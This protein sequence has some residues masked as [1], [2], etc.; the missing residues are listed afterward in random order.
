MQVER[1]IAAI[2]VPFAVGLTASIFFCPVTGHHLHLIPVTSTLISLTAALLLLWSRTQTW[3]P[4]ILTATIAVIFVS[5]GI[6]TGSSGHMLSISGTEDTGWWHEKASAFGNAMSSAIDHIPF[7]NPASNGIIKALITGERCGIPT[8]VAE[9]FRESGAAHILALSGLHLG[10]IYG[11]LKFVLSFAGNTPAARIMKSLTVILCCGFYTS[12]TGCGPS[13]TRAFLFILIGES[14]AMTGRKAGLAGILMTS[15]LI[16]TVMNPTSVREAGFQMSYAAVAGIAFIYPHLKK[17][18]PDGERKE[19]ML[20]ASMRWIWN[21]ASMSISCQLTTGPLA[22]VYF[23][24]LP[25]YF[26]LT[27]LIAL[28]LTGILIP[29]ALV[30]LAA[31]EA[32]VCPMILI[33]VTEALV[34]GLTEALRIIAAP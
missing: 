32:G 20:P 15:F 14:A 9:A 3:N 1:D 22:Y 7:D 21:S 17:L 10:I 19:A 4:A 34:S 26:I 25:E 30:T 6:M 28:P 23:G 29:A 8:E 24:T 13:I 16:Q 2:T 12:A 11:L 31:C 5:A 27:N 33:K 18:W